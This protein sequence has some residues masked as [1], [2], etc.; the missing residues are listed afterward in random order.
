LAEVRWPA[1][2]EVVARRPTVIVD[3]AHNVASIE[4]LLATL[5]ESFAAR[6]RILVFATTQE[7][8]IEGM[9]AQLLPRFDRVIFTQYRNNPRGVPPAELVE[10][11][12]RLG[13]APALVCPDPAAAWRQVTEL[14]SEDDLVCITG[15][16]FIAA[17]MRAQMKLHPLRAADAVF[18]RT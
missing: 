1:R 18:E 12:A 7:K 8:E 17:E 6:Q 10:A 11:A 16:F 14:A 13:E 2:V 3:A 9:L 5:E 15:S 4:A